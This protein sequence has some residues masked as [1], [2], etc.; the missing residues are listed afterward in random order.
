LQQEKLE[1]AINSEGNHPYST[2]AEK[3]GQMLNCFIQDN[4]FMYV[5]R[6]AEYPSYHDQRTHNQVKNT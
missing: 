3:K 1:Q 2:L 4:K 6:R 5:V